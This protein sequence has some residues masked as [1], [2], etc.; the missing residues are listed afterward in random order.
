MTKSNRGFFNNQGDVTKINEPT[1]P[2]FE[3][4]RDFIHVCLIYKFQEDLVNI[5]RVMLMAKFSAIKGT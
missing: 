2:G 1:W 3:L 5:E 4:I